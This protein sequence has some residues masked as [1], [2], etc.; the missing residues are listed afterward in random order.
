MD[1]GPVW[2]VAE[3]FS[4]SWDSISVQCSPQHVATPAEISRPLCKTFHSASWGAISN[5]AADF[6]TLI[7]KLKCCVTAAFITDRN[8]L[9]SQTQPQFSCLILI[10]FYSVIILLCTSYLP[11][12]V[13]FRWVR[14]ISESDCKRPHVRLSAWNNSAPPDVFSKELM[15]EYFFFF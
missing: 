11:K 5:Q 14:K 2:T 13:T 6:A 10:K 3:I 15:I 9:I 12:D 4:F 7:C 1:P 8:W